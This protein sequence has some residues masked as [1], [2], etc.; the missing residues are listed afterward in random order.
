MTLGLVY[1]C[2]FI[3]MNNF[4]TEIL[5]N[6]SGSTVISLALQ[7]LIAP[8]SRDHHKTVEDHWIML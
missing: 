4:S 5:Q 3:C 6:D 1:F 7:L 2:I 8:P